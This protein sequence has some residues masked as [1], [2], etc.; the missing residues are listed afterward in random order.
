M[1]LKTREDYI[2]SL[3]AMRP[4]VYKF[5]KLISDVTTDPATRRTVESHARAFDAAYD[6]KYA[7]IATT[8][9]SFT[10]EKI[11]RFTSL[12]E[13]LEDIMY[14]S[15][16]K[17]MMY[18]LTGTCTGGTCV[19]WNA[20]NVMWNVTYEMDKEYGTNYQE[21][22]KKWILYAQENG[23]VVAGALTD[24]KGDRSLRAS[25]QPDLDSNLR[26]KE[27]RDDGIVIRGCKAMICGV[28]ASNEIFLLPGSAYREE[29]KD[30]AVACVV[31]RDIEGLTIVETRRPSDERELE[32]NFDIPETGISQAYLIFEDVFIPN[33]RVFMC[34]EFKYTGKIIQYFT[35]NYRACIG[36]C[37]AGQGD[38]MIGAAALIAR[39]NGLAAGTFMNKIIEMAINNETTYGLGIGAMAAGKKHPA[40]AWVSDPLL[41]HTNKVL[42]ATLPYETKRLCQDIGGGIVETGCFPSYKDFMS[43]EYGHL[44]QKYVKAGARYSAETRARAARLIE[45]LT[46]GAGVP[47]CM[48]GGGSPDGAKL[49]VRANIPLEEFAE[50]ARKLAGITEEMPEPEKKK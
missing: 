43:P 50:Y 35:A 11:H 26:I 12:M 16:F 20:L 32:N 4:N 37:V 10:G 33:D 38:V 21:R 46:I 5:G 40:G 13:S 18:H 27:I 19:G 41:A 29:D 1:A 14:N 39:A 3:K 42:V 2:K 9:S 22:L 47:G 6:P 25:Q 23:L 49:V 15:K 36:A 17:R 48:H 28:A 45:W 31:P 44:V 30:F 8:V 24:A 7:E 34:K